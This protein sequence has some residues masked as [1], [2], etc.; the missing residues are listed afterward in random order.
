MEAHVGE[1]PAVGRGLWTCLAVCRVGPRPVQRRLSCARSGTGPVFRFR[2]GR[3]MVAHKTAKMYQLQRLS[4]VNNA[5]GGDVE[6]LTSRRSPCACKL[7]ETAQVKIPVGSEEPRPGRA[8]LV[9]C[10]IHIAII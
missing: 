10:E 8:W 4:T 6:S 3:N 2:Q 7:F 9:I 5:G 1:V